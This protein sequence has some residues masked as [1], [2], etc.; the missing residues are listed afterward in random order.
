MASVLLS[1]E[2]QSE[3]KHV[4]SILFPR[5]DEGSIPSWSTLKYPKKGFGSN[6]GMVNFKK[7]FTIPSSF[8][9]IKAVT[10]HCFPAIPPVFG[11]TV[12]TVLCQACSSRASNVLSHNKRK[13]ETAYYHKK[14]IHTHGRI[15]RHGIPA[16]LRHGPLLWNRLQ[17]APR[18][19]TR[20]HGHLR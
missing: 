9:S 6:D 4:E 1:H 14:T 8:F 15:F 12:L 19:T 17:L 3:D 11:Q 7:R 18:H 16:Q 10:L 2:N 5:L 13:A 20:R